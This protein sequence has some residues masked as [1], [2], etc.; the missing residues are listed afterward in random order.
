MR[1]LLGNSP[2]N[3][4]MDAYM[5]AYCAVNVSNARKALRDVKALLPEDFISMHYF[6]VLLRSMRK[7]AIQTKQSLATVHEWAQRL[8]CSC[9]E[10]EILLKEFHL[11]PFFDTEICQMQLGMLANRALVDVQ[12][13]TT[14]ATQ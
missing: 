2:L 4:S 13:V 12:I 3:E 7:L 5:N 1:S 11:G 9:M 10:A 14:N 6:Q 8:D